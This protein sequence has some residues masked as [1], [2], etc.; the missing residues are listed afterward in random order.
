MVMFIV[1]M[2]LMNMIMMIVTN[3]AESLKE[4]KE[5]I[6]DKPNLG[7]WLRHTVPEHHLFYDFDDDFDEDL[8]R[9]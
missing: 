8:I 5:N 2:I 1:V 6:L 3:L 7:C 9:G 4:G